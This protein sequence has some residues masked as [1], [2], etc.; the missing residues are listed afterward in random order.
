MNL[1]HY[2]TFGCPAY[3]LDT[4]LSSGGS[5]PK[6]NPRARRGIYLGLL[7]EHASNVALIYNPH[8]GFVS[9]Q[10]HVVCNNDF[11]SV[12]GASNLDMHS[13][14]EQLFATNRDIP[15]DDYL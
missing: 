14:W 2:H 7:P 13:I 10:Y 5:I 9:P 8:T 1:Q 11:T 15:P 3:I 4:R 12:D 6:W